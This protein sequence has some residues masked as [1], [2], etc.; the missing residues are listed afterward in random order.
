MLRRKKN[1]FCLLIVAVLLVHAS[2]VAVATS[3]DAQFNNTVTA[4]SV[5]TISDSGF[6][7]ITNQYRGFPGKTTKAEITTYIE[8]RTFGF[9]WSRVDIG[10]PNN[11]WHDVIYD[12][13]YAG[14]HTFQLTSPGTYRI[15]VVFVIY[16]SGG[17]PD[18]ITRVLNT[19]Y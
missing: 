14:Y 5:A 7:T 13:V 18:T 11:E 4:S 3:F 1:L 10:E 19:T 12:Y 8:K 17:E 9:F 15:T 2:S 6:L 16:G